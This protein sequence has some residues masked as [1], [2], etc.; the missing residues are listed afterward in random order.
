MNTEW[1]D[2]FKNKC[3]ER[4]KNIIELC[5]SVGYSDTGVNIYVIHQD[6]IKI[7]NKIDGIKLDC[8]ES[9][10]SILIVYAGTKF[11]NCGLV[12]RKKSVVLIED[13]VHNIKNVKILNNNGN[14][15][16]LYIGKNFN[17]NGCEIRL[18][19]Y[20]N[21]FIG[22][23]C[24]FSW[25]VKIFTSDGHA[26]VDNFG[27]LINTPDDV[28]I[29]DN[30]WLGYGSVL[31]KGTSINYGSVVGAGSIV[32]KKFLDN[33]VIIAGSPAN[34]IRGGVNWMRQRKY[35]IAESIIK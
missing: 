28:V 26:I 9:A 33:N 3:I 13:S 8:A 4:T 2:R 11:V 7:V 35:K 16:V 27:N 34:V 32:T 14:S 15:S 6:E 29:A 18:W 25:D 21:V 12:F 22:S 17:C 1:I 5:K 31:L 23:E 30:V 10:G 20:R 24:M 19:E